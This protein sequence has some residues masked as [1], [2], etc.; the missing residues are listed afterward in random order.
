GTL[1]GGESLVDALEATGLCSSRGD[2]RR[3]IAGGGVR[4]NGQRVGTEVTALPDEAVVGGRFVLLQ[5]GKRQRHLLLIEGPGDG[6]ADGP[7]V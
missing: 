5:K 2:A 7:T 4:V 1:V 3:T 6:P